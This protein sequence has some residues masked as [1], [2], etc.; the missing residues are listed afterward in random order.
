MPRGLRRFP[1]AHCLH[2]VT[3]SCYRREPRLGAEA[4][5]DS[6]EAELER[7]RKWYR[8]FVTG[9][10]VM[11]EHVHL[12]VSEPERSSLPVAIQML[13]QNVARLWGPGRLWQIRYYDY[14]VRSEKKRIEKLQYMHRNPVARG[15]VERPEDWRW[16]SFRHY[17]TGCEGPVEIESQ[18]TAR[19][20]E[21]MGF[22][23]RA[24]RHDA[25]THPVAPTPG[26]TRMGQPRGRS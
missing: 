13:K 16:S 15:L 26:A 24:F 1:N 11:P 25:L 21:R 19:W 4:V 20:R 14:L 18:W 5:R 9:Y 3:F 12:L 22:P 23:L 2:F 6:V 17:A 8:L 10:V 7:V